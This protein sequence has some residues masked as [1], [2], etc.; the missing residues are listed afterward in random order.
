M[1][2]MKLFGR[3][4]GA[5]PAR[6][7]RQL[8]LAEADHD[9]VV[10]VC[11]EALAARWSSNEVTGTH[12]TRAGLI[13]RGHALIERGEAGYIMLGALDPLGYVAEP[14]PARSR[15]CDAVL[16]TGTDPL[17]GLDGKGREDIEE[18]IEMLTSRLARLGHVAGGGQ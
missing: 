13:V 17:H 2:P 6:R 12:H 7:A 16:V 15:L 11:A 5:A 18:A 9:E 14:Y 4:P 8:P 10:Q 1:N 3:R